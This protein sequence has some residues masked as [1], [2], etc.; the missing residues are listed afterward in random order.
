MGIG[1]K[2]GGLHGNVIEWCESRFV[3][4]GAAAHRG[5]WRVVRGGSCWNSA[6]GCRSAYRFWNLPAWRNEYIG[7]RV[8][9]APAPPAVGGR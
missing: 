6:D 9:L 5:A 8:V 7:F 1:R 3:P 2:L 4:Y